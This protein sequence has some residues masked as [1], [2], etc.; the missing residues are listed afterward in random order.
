ME[1]KKKNSS[2]I[3]TLAVILTVTLLASCTKNN[4][5]DRT[6]SL[7]V[8][9]SYLIAGQPIVIKLYQQKLVT[10][11]AVYGAA[12]TGIKLYLSNGS[13]QVQLTESPLGTYTYSD[14]TFLVAGKTY[15]MQFAYLGYNVSANTV[16]P[17]KPANFIS[18][19]T[20]VNIPTTNTLPGIAPPILN[21]L[22]WSN[23]D[24]LYHVI[25]FK[26]INTI[27]AIRNFGDPPA[28]F[29]VNAGQAPYYNITGNIFS[30][31][32]TYQVVLL[33]V[34]Q[35]YINWLKN[36][37]RTSS[38][39]LTQSYTNITNGFGIFTAMQADTLSL[40]VNY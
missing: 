36:S 27:V 9:Q 28:N 24:S 17:G 8:V 13:K 26:G 32:G 22:A 34:N 6:V 31:Y 18:Q 29:E 23:P 39:N 21:V 38:Q 4:I 1:I 2:L 30:Y 14:P 20:N 10:D 3:Y 25:E 33:R 12:I 35:E 11:T 5:D 40:N 16:M 37:S 7:P 15:N 19:Y